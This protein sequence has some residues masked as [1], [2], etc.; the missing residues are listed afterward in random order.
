MRVFGATQSAVMRA[1]P[2]GLML[3]RT[4]HATPR[5]FVDTPKPFVID[6]HASVEEVLQTYDKHITERTQHHLGVR[7]S[8]KRL[9]VVFLTARASPVP[10]QPAGES[11]SCGVTERSLTQR[12]TTTRSCFRFSATRST[13]WATRIARPTTACTAVRLSW[14][15]STISRGCG[16]CRWKTRGAT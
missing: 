16:I 6:Q 1:V 10:V 11:A 2:R 8:L 5:A 4:M 7:S 3:A 12:S 9:F 14:R 15:W 13:T